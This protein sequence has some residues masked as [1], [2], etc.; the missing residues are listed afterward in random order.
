MTADDFSAHSMAKGHPE[1][2]CARQDPHIP[3]LAKIPVDLRRMKNHRE[4]TAWPASL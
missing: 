3:E 1:Y 4:A 2:A